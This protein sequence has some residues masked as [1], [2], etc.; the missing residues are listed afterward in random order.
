MEKTTRDLVHDLDS[1]LGG[2]L[3]N[4]ESIKTLKT[5]LGRASEDMQ[6]I[7]I[8]DKTA[9]RMQFVESAHTV[10]LVDDLLGFVE[11]EIALNYEDAHRTH[12][13]LFHSI[14]KEGK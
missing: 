14:M 12:N 1:K 4:I 11:R 13:E 5:E 3:I 6:E 7:D 9:V 2:V 10:K 8:S